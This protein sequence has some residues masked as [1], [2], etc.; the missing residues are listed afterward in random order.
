M[1]TGVIPVITRHPLC[2]FPPAMLF[3][4]TCYLLWIGSSSRLSP[5]GIAH[6]LLRH[7][8]RRSG[9]LV[10]LTDRLRCRQGQHLVLRFKTVSRRQS[11]VPLKILAPSQLAIAIAIAASVSHP[12]HRPC[13]P[14]AHD[15]PLAL[16]G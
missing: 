12:L 14:A 5:V 2:L 10:P 1:P 16:P 8:A 3:V 15:V 9:G 4:T 11:L 7:L 6:H 13:C